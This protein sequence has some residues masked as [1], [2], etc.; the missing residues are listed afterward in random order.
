MSEEPKPAIV[1]RNEYNCVMA[2]TIG[3]CFVHL[4]TPVNKYISQNG[5]T[6]IL[7]VF[8]TLILFFLHFPVLRWERRGKKANKRKMMMFE[9]DPATFHFSAKFLWIPFIITI[10]Y[11]FTPFSTFR[12]F[13]NLTISIPDELIQI[14]SI[15]IKCSKL[16][17]I[18]TQNSFFPFFFRIKLVFLLLKL[19]NNDEQT[20][21]HDWMSFLIWFVSRLML[22]EKPTWNELL[23]VLKWSEFFENQIEFVVSCCVP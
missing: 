18:S 14:S 3:F 19:D 8:S 15:S 17:S 20:L 11:C 16:I 23:N 21:N 5:M 10:M 13:D 1:H 4:S 7:F 12:Q 22:S 6:F 2:Q 9:V